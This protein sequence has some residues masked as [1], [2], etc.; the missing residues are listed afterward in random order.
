MAQYDRT[1]QPDEENNSFY[2]DEFGE[3]LRDDEALP[4]RGEGSEDTAASEG[5]VDL[6]TTSL[7]SDDA[8]ATDSSAFYEQAPGTTLDD[9]YSM[10]SDDEI[11]YTPLA[12]DDDYDPLKFRSDE[13]EAI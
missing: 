9:S 12:D 10:P 8:L 4:E 13:D 1:D 2:V 5:S 3:Q 7:P 11:G 6:G